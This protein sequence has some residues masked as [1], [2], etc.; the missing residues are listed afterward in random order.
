ME[1]KEINGTAQYLPL[2][3]C[4]DSRQPATLPSVHEQEN[5]VVAINEL[6]QLSH[7]LPSLGH[8]HLR[9]IHWVAWHGDA[10][11]VTF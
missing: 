4:D 11:V 3:G 1:G 10:H 6:L 2:A 5:N 9:K 7:V 8:R